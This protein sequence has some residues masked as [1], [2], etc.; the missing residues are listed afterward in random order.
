MGMVLGGEIAPLW[1]FSKRV[2]TYFKAKRHM[3]LF[4]GIYASLDA[5]TPLPRSSELFRWILCQ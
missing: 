5:R 1:E 2:R 3:P 4:A